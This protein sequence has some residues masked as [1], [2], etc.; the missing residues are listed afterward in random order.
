[1][2][3]ASTRG[4]ARYPAYT[5]AVILAVLASALGTAGAAAEPFSDA[6]SPAGPEPAP[7]PATA[8]EHPHLVFPVIGEARLTDDWHQPRDNGARLHLGSDIGADKHAALVAVTDGVIVELRHGTGGNSGN[9][10][11]LEDAQG[12]RYSYM[13][14]NNDTP[15]TDDG[16]N[17]FE[18]AFATGLRQGMTVAAGDVIGYV[19]DSG[20]A[21]PNT[22]HLHFELKRPDGVTINPY[23]YLLAA[24]PAD[25][26][27]LQYLCRGASNSSFEEG[28]AHYGTPVA[29]LADTGVRRVL[30]GQQSEAI[31]GVALS[32]D[33]RGIW[34]L[35]AN[36][37]L[38]TYG[39]VPHMGVP[40]QSDLASDVVAIQPT[41]SGQGYWLLEANGRVHSFGDA[42]D[43]GWSPVLG[44]AEAVDLSPTSSGD[45]Y[46]VLASDATVSAHGDAEHLGSPVDFDTTTTFDAVMIRPTADGGG[47]WVLAEDGRVATFG[48]AVFR[49]RWAGGTSCRWAG[50]SGAIATGD[51][52]GWW[53]VDSE[54]QAWAFGSARSPDHPLPVEFDPG[55]PSA[56]R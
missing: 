29:A 43:R 12:W 26:S 34:A 38:E 22:P 14:L 36:G 54:L 52:S 33:A 55:V 47:Y 18:E 48:N 23:P 2:R 6:P 45:G 24:S 13:H 30:G 5:I 28:I 31:I 40:D 9:M 4:A 37:L 27:T 11:V 32:A 50:A 21:E 19:G 8:R 25:E 49:G 44:S 41:G 53:I 15:G 39:S 17:R 56:A 16:R 20:N 10:L 46:Y 3:D 7:E 42:V 35:T 51:G 1:M